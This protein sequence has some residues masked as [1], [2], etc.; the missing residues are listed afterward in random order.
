MVFDTHKKWFFTREST[1]WAWHHWMEAT[2][3]HDSTK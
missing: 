1:C 3:R 2:G